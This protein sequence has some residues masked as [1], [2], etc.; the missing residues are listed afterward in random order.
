MKKIETDKEVKIIISSGMI[1]G[2][3]S[4]RMESFCLWSTAQLQ[5]TCWEK[6]IK[7]IFYVHSALTSTTSR[8]SDQDWISE[9][10][11]LSSQFSTA[12]WMDRVFLT[13]VW[14]RN[15]T[16]NLDSV[17]I[18]LVARDH[19]PIQL[20][21]TSAWDCS[22]LSLQYRNRLSINDTK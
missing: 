18:H 11:Q 16:K 1:S 10:C 7:K 17:R 21:C 12:L 13:S 22:I 9:F 8:I 4:P 5:I 14:S 2:L 15:L 20:S 3:P 19:T 6:D